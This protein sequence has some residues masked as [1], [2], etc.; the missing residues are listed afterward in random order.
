MKLAEW[1]ATAAPAAF[2]LPLVFKGPILHS[3]SDLYFS[4]RTSMKQP[5]SICDQKAFNRVPERQHLLAL[6]LL[7][8]D[9]TWAWL[10]LFMVGREAEVN[11]NIRRSIGWSQGLA[12]LLSPFVWKSKRWKRLK[13]ITEEIDLTPFK[14]VLQQKK[15]IFWS[16]DCTSF[17]WPFRTQPLTETTCPFWRCW[18]GQK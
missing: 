9:K 7:L 8:P 10:E 18:N 15:D 4:S 11:W 13:E 1:V 17:L 2:F 14:E 12:G 3:L 6:C 5:H 16:E